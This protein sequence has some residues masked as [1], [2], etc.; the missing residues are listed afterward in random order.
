MDNDDAVKITD[1]EISSLLDKHKTMMVNHDV[2]GVGFGGQFIEGSLYIG[3]EKQE[4]IEALEEEQ[5]YSEL[6]VV[7]LKELLADRGLPVS[8]RKAELIERLEEDDESSGGELI[9]Q[10]DVLD[11]G[12]A[13]SYDEL[14]EFVDDRIE[15]GE[16][17][18]P[19]F[20][21]TQFT[22]L[23][24]DVGTTATVIVWVSS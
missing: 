9:E 23:D 8:G 3:V 24:G 18:E 2:Y 13:M 15:D 14:N 6:K 22:D 21:T 7:E 19:A 5:D 1:F 20:F 17:D 10:E 4:A 16:G 11:E 12:S